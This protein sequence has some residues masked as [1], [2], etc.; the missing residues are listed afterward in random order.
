MYLFITY[1][2]SL[3]MLWY[4]VAI[5]TSSKKGVELIVNLKKKKRCIYFSTLCLP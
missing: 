3:N 1:F 2:V 5:F 4:I